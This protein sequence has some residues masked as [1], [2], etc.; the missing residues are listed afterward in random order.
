MIG[1]ATKEK[2]WQ[3]VEDN[4]EYLMSIVFHHLDDSGPAYQE[5][6][7]SKSLKT[8]R[9]IREELEF[10]KETKNP[11]LADYFND[12]WCL[13]SDNYAWSVPKWGLFC[14]L[15]SETWVFEE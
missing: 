6:G 5:P 7:D 2:Y 10:L 8:G 3:A 13:A 9:N 1:I 12:A 11:K 14:D 15:C 4:W